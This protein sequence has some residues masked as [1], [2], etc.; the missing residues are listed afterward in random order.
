[1]LVADP[2]V[3]LEARR[4][5]HALYEYLSP[6]GRYGPVAAASAFFTPW[7]LEVISDPVAELKGLLAKNAQTDVGVL[8]SMYA[9]AAYRNPSGITLSNLWRRSSKVYARWISLISGTVLR[10]LRGSW[11]P[12]VSTQHPPLTPLPVRLY[13]PMEY[14][15]MHAQRGFRLTEG[16]AEEAGWLLGVYRALGGTADLRF[17]EALL[18]WLLPSGEQSLVEVLWAS[19]RAGV[20]DELEP[21][22]TDAS[23]LYGWVH[24]VLDP[25][26]RLPLTGGGPL[27]KS[28]LEAALELPHHKLYKRLARSFAPATAERGDVIGDIRALI[29][30]VDPVR[31]GDVVLGSVAEDLGRRREALRE[32]LR[33]HRL[34]DL[35]RENVNEAYLH[36]LY[37]VSGSDAGLLDPALEADAGTAGQRLRDVAR[38]LVRS[39]ME[40]DSPRTGLPL[41]F[42][43]DESFRWNLPLSGVA[44]ASAD[45]VRLEQRVERLVGGLR[46]ELRVH[47]G[48]AAEA[49]EMLPPF[50]GRVWWATAEARR[51]SVGAEFGLPQ[52]H[53]VSTEL[54]GVLDALP[55]GE[56]VLNVVWSVERS[57]ARDVSP[58]ARVAGE[59]VALY[60]AATRFRVASVSSGLRYDES[61]GAHFVDVVLTEA[62]TEQP[63]EQSADRWSTGVLTWPLKSADGRD[64]G[65]AGMNARDRRRFGE[66]FRRSDSITSWRV[67]DANNSPVGLPRSMSWDG[68]WFV[69]LTHASPKGIF[70]VSRYGPRLVDGSH[71]GTYLKSILKGRQLPP[72]T[73]IFSYA[74]KSA[75]H[76]Q[77]IADASEHDVTAPTGPFGDWWGP[78][79]SDVNFTHWML[80]GGEMPR[81]VDFVPRDRGVGEAEVRA[82]DRAYAPYAG[83]FRAYYK[84]SLWAEL[85]RDYERDLGEVLAEDPEVLGAARHMLET[86]LP[87]DAKALVPEKSDDE[88]ELAR[89]M[90]AATEAAVRGGLLTVREQPS[91]RDG[92]RYRVLRET[93]GFHLAEGRSNIARGLL[94]AY[95]DRVPAARIAMARRAV[96]GW[97]LST[98]A[99]SLYEALSDTHEVAE[100]SPTERVVLLGDAAHLYAWAHAE[101]AAG[102]RRHTPYQALYTGR[103]VW[104]TSAL[105]QDAD[106]PLDITRIIEEEESAADG[107]LPVGGDGGIRRGAV[108]EWLRRH[109][110]FSPLDSLMGGHIAAVYLFN[111]EPD[112]GLL[113]AGLDERSGRRVRVGRLK[114]RVADAIAQGL[115]SL[116]VVGRSAFPLL[117]ARDERFS[118][119][120]DQALDV[121]LT[122]ADRYEQLA[123]L[124]EAMHAQFQAM[125]DYLLEEI[126]EHLGMVA[127]ALGS[128]PPVMS[129]VWFGMWS[130]EEGGEAFHIPAFR[131][132]TFSEGVAVAALP[133]HDPDSAGHRVVV[134]V[135]N[136]SARD[137]SF[138]S[139]SPDRATALYPDGGME[140]N[141]QDRSWREDVDGNRYEYVQ[142]TEAEPV[143]QFPEPVRTTHDVNWDS[144]SEVSE[145]HEVSGEELPGGGQWNAP[146]VAGPPADSAYSSQYA[147]L[148]SDPD[149]AE[150]IEE[151][152]ITLGTVLTVDPNVIWEAQNAVLALYNHLSPPGR[153]GP[154]AA[155]RAFF[156]PG[157]LKDLPDPVAQIENL[158]AEDAEIDVD[159]LMSMFA[160]AAY[161][162]PSGTTLSKLWPRSSGLVPPPRSARPYSPQEHE[163]HLA[164][165]L[166]L[167]QSPAEE[168]EWLLGV[169]RALGGTEDLL[170]REALLGWLLESG[171]QSLV[172]VLRASH[173]AGVR[174]ELEPDF[175]DAS[176]LYGWVQGVLDPKERLAFVRREGL[177]KSALKAGLDLP[178]HRLYKRLARWIAPV[179]AERG[180]VI[181]DIGALIRGVDPVASGDVVLGSVGEELGRRREA[182]R[183]WLRRHRLIDLLKENVNEA[184]LY[185]LYLVSGVD[186]GLLD[187]ALE[188]DAGKAGQ[189]LRDVARS[190]V[191]SAMESD[192]PRT[193]LPL[194]FLRD[195]SF[196]G[197]LPLSG[198]AP[199]PVDVVGLEQRVERLVGGLRGELRV[200]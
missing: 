91:H 134:E 27:M 15:E 6:P 25:K 49:L 48:M 38:S 119:L 181:G 4:A 22:F 17:R 113:R 166:R 9:W 194:L 183:D 55:G 121:P 159:E 148:Y 175:S 161:R 54:S 115:V 172:E 171:E 68:D 74:C 99:D 162:N 196:R 158:V 177:D 39:A 1:M 130:A 12:E 28:A 102:M 84:H 64:L 60:P 167:T 93:R 77:A 31:S 186:A 14:Q 5:V 32:W 75:V 109:A 33:R 179:T 36:A 127:E 189:R 180:D 40:S 192:S 76:G 53:R 96:L 47:R 190:L 13:S 154:V 191:R 185:A 135:V 152:E 56:G 42:L 71:W 187:P 122:A 150:R 193:G 29:R 92:A 131:E 139:P 107:V 88:S 174:D 116:P 20:R 83:Q 144:V 19:H 164:R 106:V 82:E 81:M 199:T 90:T 141:V 184:Y 51:P 178:H 120:I 52:F 133:A 142:V 86:L 188:A 176:Q 3:V 79:A 168:A 138:L 103:H 72:G 2:K 59:R 173:R 149:W 7:Q 46:G 23:Q 67:I 200:H 110:P 43:R 163:E 197:L 156:T 94:D 143:A 62:D 165:G 105:T 170:F 195:E 21:D 132:V 160:L 182:L 78:G 30:G 145:A 155:A 87:K 151:Y 73:R 198:V 126:P 45:I 16:S 95:H 11:R 111:S 153:Y 26:E 125:A 98:G 100:V 157:Q 101:F 61:T 117:L 147:D 41:L 112:R 34:I 124:S 123:P 80:R 35:L 169:Y 89:L 140:L 57:S 44:P 50:P 18:G 136:S 63:S 114:Q 97:L 69:A 85:A 37:L 108:R 10:F 137:V 65:V 8:M 70:T 129:P 128:L 118:A 104:L 24:G 66:H 58:L 146:V